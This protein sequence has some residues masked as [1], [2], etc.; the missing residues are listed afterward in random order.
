MV[1]YGREMFTALRDKPLHSR[2][3]WIIATNMS[4]D[5]IGRALARIQSAS[6]RIEAAA[7]RVQAGD[8]ELSRKYAALREESGQVLEEL[9][10]LIGQFSK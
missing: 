5:R 3:I 6:S 10:Q 8:P 9:D 2:A 1:Q 4:G 7:N